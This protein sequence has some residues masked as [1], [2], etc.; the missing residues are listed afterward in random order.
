[1]IKD[2]FPTIL[3][4]SKIK[5]YWV[6]IENLIVDVRTKKCKMKCLDELTQTH[7]GFSLNLLP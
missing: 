3:N 6:R 1:M 5:I 4:I 2:V 7:F